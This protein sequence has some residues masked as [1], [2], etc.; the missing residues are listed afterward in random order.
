MIFSVA[1][2]AGTLFSLTFTTPSVAS[3]TKCTIL[4][5]GRIGQNIVPADF[6]KPS[7]V[8][9][10]LFDHGQSIYFIAFASDVH[11]VDPLVFKTRHLLKSSNFLLFYH[12]WYVLV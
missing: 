11:L 9:N 6:D 7:S 4:F 12:P 2:F 5:D 10:N 1:L 3:L 8:Y